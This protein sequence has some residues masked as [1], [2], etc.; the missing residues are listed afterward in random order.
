MLKDTLYTL[1]TLQNSDNA[2]YATLLLNP[3]NEIFSGHYPEQPV[4]PG[5]C[6]LQMIQEVMEI[7]FDQCVQLIK[8]NSMKFLS[9]INPENDPVLQ[10]KVSYQE[11]EKLQIKVTATLTVGQTV[12]FKLQGLY[13]QIMKC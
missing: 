2:I 3:T 11:V 7:A 5:A 13:Q 8:A 9:M 12:S 10:L 6:A 4:L 1:Q